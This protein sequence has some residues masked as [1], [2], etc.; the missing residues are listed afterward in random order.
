MTDETYLPAG[1]CVPLVMLGTATLADLQDW[2]AA[3]LS[4]FEYLPLA[5]IAFGE[6][7]V[8]PWASKEQLRL[9]GRMAVWGYA[10]DDH[11]ERKITDLGELDGFLARCNE[12]VRTGRR[13]DG[14]ALLA[15]LS[16]WQEEI[17]AQPGYPALADVWADKFDSC[18]RGHRYDW[19]V[20][21]ARERGESPAT[22]VEEYLA[23]ADSSAIGQVH[24]PRWI[25]YGDDELPAHLDVLVPALD[26]VSVATRLANDLATI[27][28]ERDEAGAN[29]V[30]MYGVSDDWVRDEIAARMTA[31]RDRLAP[32]T[33]ANYLPAVGLVRI[34]EWSVGIYARHDMRLATTMSQAMSQAVSQ[35]VSQ[36]APTGA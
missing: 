28:R 7:V 8:G 32:L 35:A 33:A 6:A 29:N 4:G 16:S 10:L 15:S 19:V 24:V 31:V 25:A 11:I 27:A 22:S 20:G 36:P 3:H 18:L 12:V 34:A 1:P 13:D 23:H 26:D 5:G 2:T 14:N 9:T 17:S 21:W 30:L